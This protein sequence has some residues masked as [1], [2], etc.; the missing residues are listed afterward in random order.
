MSTTYRPSPVLDQAGQY[1]HNRGPLNIYDLCLLR[2]RLDWQ[3]AV[4]TCPPLPY[5]QRPSDRFLLPP[6]IDMPQEGKPFRRFASAPVVGALV[7][8]GNQTGTDFNINGGSAA[9]PLGTTLFEVD[10]GYDGVITEVVFGI[11]SNGSTGFLDGSGLITWRLGIDY[12]QVDTQALWYPR[13]YGN[14]TNSTGTLAT[15]TYI[16]GN[17]I[18]IRSRE[19]INIWV[20]LA[21]AGI[22]I[23]N[24]NALV[25]GYVGG[26]TYPI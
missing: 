18:R 16:L 20:N 13:D 9:L 19:Q 26:W 4:Y 2:D 22:G 6:W 21:V 11:I 7:P 8:P 5:C 25:I 14:I 10:S 15:P 1:R 24:P 12:G 17:G 23:I 3:K